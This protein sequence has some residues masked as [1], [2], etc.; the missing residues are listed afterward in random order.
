MASAPDPTFRYFLTVTYRLLAAVLALPLAACLPRGVESAPAPAPGSA[1]DF[2]VTSA[3]T[4]EDTTLPVLLQRIA[5]AD[6]V[7]FGEQH[8]DAETHRAEAALLDAIGGLGRP[9]VL[10][11]EMFE[12]DVQG[13]LDDYLAGRIAEAEFRSLARPW[14]NYETD[15]RPLVEMARMR[16]WPVVAANVPRPLASAV[17]RQGL[18]ALDTLTPAERGHAA[19]DIVC[20]DDTYRARFMDAMRSHGGDGGGAASDS[21]PTAVA[22]RFYLAQCLKDETMAESIVDALRGAAEGTIVVHFNGAFHSD[23]GLGTAERVA[24]REPRLDLLVLTAI[25]SPDPAAAA[26]EEHRKRAEFVILTRRGG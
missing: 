6:V 14:P 7:F 22:E 19:K 9:V 3:E 21:L 23:F 18:A 26:V 16:S 1:W 12:T 20:P 11:L 4:G 8:D 17:G 13:V 5:R 10:S 25:P 15:Y 2:R 24:R